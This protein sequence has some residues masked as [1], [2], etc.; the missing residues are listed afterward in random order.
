MTPPAFSFHI[1]S[2][3]RILLK[4]LLLGSGGIL[5][6]D[7]Y[8]EALMLTP[9]ATE[10]PYYPDHLP[11]DQDNDLLRILGGNSPA[12]GVVTEFGGR[13]LNADGK[14]VAEAVVELWQADHNGCY[15]HSRGLQHGKERD[16]LFQGYG[17]ITTN[18]KG[19]YRFR[20]IKPGH[21]TGRT[22]HWHIAVN[23]KGKRVL[24]TQLFIAGVAQNDGDGVL[25]KMGTEEQRISV[26]REFLP[27]ASGSEEL[28]ATWDIVLGATPQEPRPPRAGAD[29][30]SPGPRPEGRTRNE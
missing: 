28:V 2:S 3:R 11:L 19:E 5:T 18:Q 26:I 23:Q 20:T 6:A 15:L 17:K 14:P 22:I 25:K 24:T 1:P 7:L 29:V 21:Y 16:P 4:S 13:L 30:P 9:S 10:G 27:P 12:Q 8:A